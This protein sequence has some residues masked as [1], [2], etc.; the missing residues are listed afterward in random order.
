L[1]FLQLSDSETNDG[2]ESDS[3]QAK[4]VP[5]CVDDEAAEEDEN[6]MDADTSEGSSLC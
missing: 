3:S 1:L 5:A 4:E 6:A 2:S